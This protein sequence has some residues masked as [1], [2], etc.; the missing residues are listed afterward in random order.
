MM[1]LDRQSFNEAVRKRDK[2]QCVMCKSPASEVHHIIERKLFVDGGYVMDNGATLCGDCH[3]KAEQTIIS[4]KQ[5]RL[6]AGI[7]NVV[8][9]EGVGDDTDFDKW[10][11]PVLTNN[12]RLKG[13]LFETEQVQKVLKDANLLDLFDDYL[14]YPKSMHVP[15]SNT[16]DDDKFIES[17]AVLENE[18]V[19]VTEKMDGENSTI[20]SDGYYH[21]RSLDGRGGEDRGIVASIAARVERDLPRG[22]HICMENIY[23]QHSIAYSHLPEYCMVFSIWDENNNALSWDETIEWCDLLGLIT[24]PVLYRG[25]YDKELIH[26]LFTPTKENGDQMEG[27]VIRVTRAFHLSEF[28]ACLAKFVRKNHV[29]TSKHW[30]YQAIKKNG[31][32]IWTNQE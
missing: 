28:S 24:V 30:R 26:S 10:L 11:N 25:K 7:T 23:A 2:D 1:K 4:A 29:Q 13:P 16:S 14:K 19:V 32:K 18:E 31:L 9:P 12:R 20:Y 15:W 21:A 17:M 8:L 27:Y 5:I 22:W 3:L 6:A